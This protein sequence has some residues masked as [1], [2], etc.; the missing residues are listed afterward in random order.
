M[1]KLC[2]IFIRND[3]LVGGIETHIYRQLMKCDSDGNIGVLVT[4][5]PG[6]IGS[7]FSKLLEQPSVHI[8]TRFQINKFIKK[9]LDDNVERIIVVAFTPFDFIFADL[10]KRNI[11]RSIVHTFFFVPHY[12]GKYIY[13]EEGIPSN[14][15]K[16]R[17]G[18]IYKKMDDNDNLLYMDRRHCAEFVSRYGCSSDNKK[19]G[20]PTDLEIIKSFDEER[21]K[22][23]YY[24]DEFNIVAVSRLDFPH[25]GFILG[26]VDTFKIFKGVHPNITLTIVG[27]GPDAKTLHD[28]VADLGADY[29]KGISLI[30][31]VSPE[32]LDYYFDYAN[33]NISVGNSFSLGARRGVLSLAAR[34]FCNDCEVYGF[35]P[36]SEARSTRTD[37]G[38]AVISFLEHIIQLNYEDYKDL[39]KKCY[40]YYASSKIKSFDDLENRT[41]KT[42]SCF[43]ITFLAIN[44]FRLR[45]NDFINQLK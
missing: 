33:V 31:T 36:E 19:I 23:V 25:K 1:G 18:Y 34:N 32:K 16:K 14:R 20:P 41:T 7:Q 26:L 38:I 5:K 12:K 44:Y 39:C 42:L 8:I 35:L 43:D 29:Q 45:F 40:D 3:L 2:I 37:P 24:R 10:L 22:R 11:N 6:R 15:I 13:Y 28:R 27:D 21:V 4:K 30:G 17:L 9:V